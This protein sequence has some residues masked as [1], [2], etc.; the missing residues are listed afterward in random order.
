MFVPKINY[1]EGKT[2]QLDSMVFYNKI[3]RY[4]LKHRNMILQYVWC[5]FHNS[6]AIQIVSWSDQ[7]VYK[8]GQTNKLDNFV[9]CN[10]VNIC[11][12]KHR[13]MIFQYGWCIFHNSSAIQIVSWSDQYVYKPGKT[14]KLD[15]LVLCNKVNIYA[16]K[17]RNMILKDVWCVS[18]NSSAILIVSWSDQYVSKIKTLYWEMGTFDHTW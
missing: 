13:N 14:K 9:F 15:S 7:Y 17:H 11:A 12:L 1:R 6:S 10:K 5:I 2:K 3:D 18:H 16:L 4:A 8:L